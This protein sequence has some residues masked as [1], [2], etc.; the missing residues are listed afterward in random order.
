MTEAILLSNQVG[1]LHPRGY[2]LIKIR[3]LTKGQIL[4]QKRKGLLPFCSRVNVRKA[5]R[6]REKLSKLRMRKHGSEALCCTLS[7]V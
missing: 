5:T 3:E 6:Y 2:Q 7:A 4:R 1:V